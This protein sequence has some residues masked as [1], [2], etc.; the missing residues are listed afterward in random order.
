MRDSFEFFP[1]PEKTMFLGEI[2]AHKLLFNS[3]PDT[4]SAPEPK[5]DKS[6]KIAILEF[7]FTE[8]AISESVCPKAFLKA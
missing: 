5:L 6:F 7:A 8:Y 1:T 2:P 3:P 4:I